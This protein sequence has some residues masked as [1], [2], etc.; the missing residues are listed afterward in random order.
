VKNFSLLFFAT[1]L[2]ALSASNAFANLW[3]SQAKIEERYGP[4][5]K[6]TGYPLARKYTYAFENFEVTV[7][8]FNGVSFEETY[9][10]PTERSGFSDA[11][12]ER[13]L[14]SNSGG[15]QWYGEGAWWT[16][17]TP[18]GRAIAEHYHDET[19]P[20]LRVYT[21]ASV[22]RSLDNDGKRNERTHKEETLQGL[23][24]VRQEEKMTSLVVQAGDRVLFIPWSLEGYRVGPPI[25]PGKIYRITL[26][27]EDFV[28]AYEPIAYV[29]DRDH[30][31]FT[32]AAQDSQKNLLIRIQNG[33]EILFDRSVCEVHHIKMSEIMVE[34]DY[35]MW[36]A[37]G[38]EAYCLK[39][40]PHYRNFVLGGCIPMETKKAPLFVCLNASPA[41]SVINVS[42][43]M[44]TRISRERLIAIDPE[45]S[46]NR[47]RRAFGLA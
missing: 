21:Q 29:S 39:N 44:R 15:G 13:I 19:K 26:R 4:P 9:T 14:K 25:S 3:E 8:F 2:A 42:I 24:T 41:A 34:V 1:L 35:G 27:D 36:V 43:P 16:I 11:E 47:W 20:E 32:D 7:S 30:K 17:D 40:F 6:T 37:H 45:D 5:I 28:D 46:S 31:N 22:D 18:N 33:D 38:T 10:S 12:V 23:L